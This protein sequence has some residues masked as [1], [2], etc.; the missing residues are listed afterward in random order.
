MLAKDVKIRGIFSDWL[1]GDGD[2]LR[3]LIRDG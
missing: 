2:L 1:A 3:H